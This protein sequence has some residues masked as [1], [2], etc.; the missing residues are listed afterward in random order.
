MRY[1]F[2]PAL[3]RLY[4]VSE[5]VLLF[6][7]FPILLFTDLLSISF[8]PILLVMSGVFVWLLIRDKSFRRRRLF[9][10]RIAGSELKSIM[11]TF[12]PVAALMTLTVWW[13]NPDY[14]FILPRSEPLIYIGLLIFYPLFSVI[15]QGIAFRAF[16]L[17]RYSGII[18]GYWSIII[19]SAIMFAFGHIIFRNWVAILLTFIGGVLFAKRYLDSKSLAAS[20][21]EHTLYGIWLFTCGL[22]NFFSQML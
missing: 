20:L 2:L 1:P 7:L 12:L 18:K 17:H 3:R 6:I 16:F 15:P 9:S 13:W 19:A 5:F 4:L 21:F 22:G 10:W 11:K 8:I 14:L